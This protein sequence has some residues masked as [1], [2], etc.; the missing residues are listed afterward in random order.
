[1]LSFLG[2]WIPHRRRPILDQ[3]GPIVRAARRHMPQ[4][5]EA[6]L[7]RMAY[8]EARGYLRVHATPAVDSAMARDHQALGWSARRWEKVRDQAVNMLIDRV[9]ADRAISPPGR[10]RRAA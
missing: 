1:M 2:A 5:I 9:L 10:V 8:Y 6:R 4:L 3:A 7:T